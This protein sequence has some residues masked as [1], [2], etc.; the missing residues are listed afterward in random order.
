MEEVATVLLLV[1][2]GWSVALL[3]FFIVSVIA[4]WM[5]FLKMGE[6]GW[7][8]LIP[9]L[10]EYKLFQHTWETKWYWVWLVCMAVSAWGIIGSDMPDLLKFLLGLAATVVNCTAQYRLARCFGYGFLF[11]LGL[12]FFNPIFLL[13]LGFGSAAYLG[14]VE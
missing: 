7:F 11:A 14:N 5:I 13:I 9:F 3:L 12:M 10:R 4:E 6:P 8:G 1:F 2:L